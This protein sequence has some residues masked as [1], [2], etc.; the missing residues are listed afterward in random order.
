[1]ENRQIPEHRRLIHRLGLIVAIL[2][3]LSFLSVFVSGALNFGNFD[4]FEARGRSM[5]IRAV[6]GMAMII[7]GKAMMIYGCAGAAGAG[8][9]LDPQKMR[10]DLEPWARAQ[11]GLT[12]DAFDEMGVNL[13]SVAE[14]LAGR[15]ASNGESLEQRLRGLH[16]LFQDGILSEDEYQRAK[17]DIL[18]RA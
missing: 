4:N 17:Q 1:M 3:A 16:A 6:G 5:A 18:D 14:G 11:G 2:G 8:L 9:N 7:A 13:G 10:Q 15:T 12:K